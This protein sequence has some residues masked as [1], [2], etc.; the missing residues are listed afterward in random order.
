MASYGSPE[1]V[2][3]IQKGVIKRTH[4]ETSALEGEV[5]SWNETQYRS[6]SKNHHVVSFSPVQS[7]ASV[8]GAPYQN[9]SYTANK[10]KANAFPQA[11]HKML[12]AAVNSGFQDIVS[13]QPHG[14][15]FRI[16]DKQEF[17]KRILPT[18]FRMSKFTSF[19]RQI[20]LYCFRRLTTGNDKGASYH[21]LFRR[22]QPG[23]SLQMVRKRTKGNGPRAKSDPESEP[24]FYSLQESESAF[25]SPDDHAFIEKRNKLIV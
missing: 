16:H 9:V 2:P 18:Y 22:D 12:Q 10:T 15:A 17:A 23:L 4:Q 11:L 19:Q 20:N 25:R 3:R 24:N 1:D 7:I 13:W 21:E 5:Y 6:S 8:Q 14:Q